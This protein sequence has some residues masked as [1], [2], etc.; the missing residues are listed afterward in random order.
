MTAKVAY[1]QLLAARLAR[2]LARLPVT[3]NMV[4]S[5]SLLMGLTAAGFFAS[6]ERLWIGAGGLLF[7][8]ACLF[9]HVDGELARLTGRTSTF[10]H[11]YDRATAATVYTTGFLGIGVG[12][13]DSTLGGWAVALGLSAGI[14]IGLIFALRNQMERRYGK[15]SIKQRIT[16]GFEIEDILYLVGPVAWLD[17]LVPL[18]VAS[19]LGA[20]LYLLLS[21]VLRYRRAG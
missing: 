7:I 17:W 8:L 12:Q 3:P 1:D 5:M 19:G 6:G 14:S 11:Y 10:G 15:E 4:T 18:V 2:V 9:D 16:G 20:P 21:L 13:Q